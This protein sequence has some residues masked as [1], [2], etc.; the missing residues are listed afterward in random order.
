MPAP[1]C[2]HYLCS[3]GVRQQLLRLYSGIQ[4]HMLLLQHFC[5]LLLFS[6]FYFILWVKLGL[7]H[8]CREPSSIPARASD[9]RVLLDS[10]WLG[11]VER[12]IF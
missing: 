4:V 12:P 11:I 8:I 9:T 1:I 5:M 10:S 3:Y 6:F 7:D 2:Q